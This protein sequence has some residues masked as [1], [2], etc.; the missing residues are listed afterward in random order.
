MSSEGV[1][2]AVAADLKAIAAIEQAAAPHPWSLSQFLGSRLRDDCMLVLE[3]AQ[4][5]VAGFALIQQVLD[6]ATLLNIAVHPSEQGRGRGAELLGAVL[7]R[8]L[9]LG[10]R[11]LL[12]EVRADNTRAIALYRR[13]GFAEDGRRR[14]YYPTATGRQDALLMSLELEAAG[15]RAGN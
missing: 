13:F 11:R 2:T 4:G 6:E 3:S 15:E 10:V 9:Q 7:E 1:R 8:A 14:N 12:L 5:E